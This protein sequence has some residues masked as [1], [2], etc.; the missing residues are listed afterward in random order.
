MTLKVSRLDN[1]SGVLGSQTAGLHLDSTGDVINA[2]GKL[3][4][5]QDATF[6]AASLNNQGGAVSARGLSIHTGSGTLDNTR[7]AVSASGAA[8]IQAGNLVNQGGTVAAG[9]LNATVAG[10]DNTVG[11]VLGSSGGNL[12][13]TSAG[14][15]ANAGGKLLAAQ[16]I[17]LSAASLGNQAG[18]VAG[19]NVTVN[20][21]TWRLDNTGGAIAAA[22]ALDATAGAVTNANGVLQAGTTLTAHAANP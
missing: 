11:G 2:G 14:T 1:T 18:T 17:A 10:L 6:N 7:G 9:N 20:T 3:I 15:V 22:A 19:R 8:T 4:A 16:D 5:A 13:V 12:T 21:G